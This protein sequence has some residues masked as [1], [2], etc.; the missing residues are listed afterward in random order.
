MNTPTPTQLTASIDEAVNPFGG[1]PKIEGPALNALLH[2]MVAGLAVDPAALGTAATPLPYAQALALAT[3]TGPDA[4]R[5]GTRYR[6]TN[7]PDTALGTAGDVLVTAVGD[8]ELASTALL[9]AHVP[10][11][12]TLPTWFPT[13]TPLGAPTGETTYTYAIQNSYTRIRPQVGD[14]V[15]SGLSGDDNFKVIQLPFDFAFGGITYREVCVDSNGRVVFGPANYSS[16]YVV[17][18]LGTQDVPLVAA[19][20]TDMMANGLG[21]ISI[22]LTGKAPH[23]RLVVDYSQL[24]YVYNAAYIY[25]SLENLQQTY[26]GQIVLEESDGSIAVGQSE[27]GI[28]AQPPVF[29]LQYAGHFYQ[30]YPTNTNAPVNTTVRYTPVTVRAPTGP[31]SYAG[32]TPAIWQGQTWDFIGTDPTREPGTDPAQWAPHAGPAADLYGNT[33]LVG[34][35]I[36]YDLGTDAIGH[37]TDARNNT[38]TGGSCRFFPWGMP[39]V[40]DNVVADTVLDTSLLTTP[41]LQFAHNVLRGCHLS[42]LG[43][44]GLAVH[45]NRL[46][47]V[48]LAGYAPTGFSGVTATH[49]LNTDYQDPSNQCFVKGHVLAD[50]AAD[51]DTALAAFKG[52]YVDQVTTIFKSG[53]LPVVQPLNIATPWA[54]SYVPHDAI[55]MRGV[56]LSSSFA[57]TGQDFNILGNATLGYTRIAFVTNENAPGYTMTFNGLNFPNGLSMQPARYS[58]LSGH[59]LH[60]LKCTLGFIESWGTGSPTHVSTVTYSHCVINR[61]NNIGN[62]A[63]TN[64]LINN[65]CLGRTITS[66]AIFGGTRSATSGPY[67]VTNSTIYLAGTATVFDAALNPLYYPTFRN[68]TVVAADG[69]VTT[70]DTNVALPAAPTGLAGARTAGTGVHLSWAATAGA[71]LYQLYRSVGG[72]GFQL[73]AT[74]PYSYFDDASGEAATAG[75]TVQ[76]YVQAAN[77][78]GP[79]VATAPITVAS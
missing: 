4:F 48:T 9:L 72:A 66:G 10:D 6:L 7:R 49:G 19:C 18:A 17:P 68:C 65:A 11:Y 55:E 56:D 33:V 8:H 51:L 76:Y 32:G 35:A 38:V 73:L 27:N 14:F 1:D 24:R 62:G 3:A 64:V 2:K 37:R 78:T 34:D 77:A 28:T 67:V 16:Q 57:F 29:G 21:N 31:V 70:L 42:G 75:S 5:P 43:L 23:R 69:T 30:P 13:H 12:Q 50:S 52:K 15:E 39:G 71:T 59:N 45:H 58:A 36:G 74:I 54:Q 22:F 20:W 61:V 63:V 41:N 40:H 79:G 44:A 60:F 46:D 53:Q 26:T 25:N 47:Q